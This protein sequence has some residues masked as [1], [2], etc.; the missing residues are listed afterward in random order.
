MPTTIGKGN[1]R[2]GI[3]KK[4]PKEA[5]AH[6]AAITSIIRVT[7]GDGPV[8]GRLKR[9]LGGLNG[10]FAV[11]DPINHGRNREYPAHVDA[12]RLGGNDV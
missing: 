11:A 3:E 9:G 4:V 10:Q 5:T 6:P 1:R 7:G 2:H 8:A 12:K